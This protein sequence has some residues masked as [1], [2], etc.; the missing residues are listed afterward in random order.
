MN[1]NLSW[2]R[3]VGGGK[4]QIPPEDVRPFQLALRT[5]LMSVALVLTVKAQDP[6]AVR[7]YL[8]EYLEPT[9][10]RNAAFYIQP[11]GKDGEL[12][13]GRIFSMDGKLKAE[14]RFKDEACTIEEG[15]FVF[16]HP[17]GKVESQGT[18]AMGN[19]SGVW[20]RFDPWGNALAEKVYDPEP[21]ANI[22]YTR[23]Q[24]MPTMPGGEKALVRTIRE[25]LD[26]TGKEVKGDAV[27]S[28]IVEKNGDLSEVKVVESPDPAIDER[29]VD[30]IRSTAPWTPGADKGIPVRV[31]MR[32]PVQ[33]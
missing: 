5:A 24:T 15:A 17:N 32:V 10:K 29:M 9:T 2:N 19:K 11:Q 18:Y 30:V 7:V 27:A 6:K 31:Q 12:F 22:I 1:R 28:F 3:R 33:F 4:N 16:Y 8:S 21:L 13:L 26:P 23:A 14:G 20:L 25:K